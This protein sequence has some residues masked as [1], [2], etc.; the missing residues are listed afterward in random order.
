M[1]NFQNMDLYLIPDWYS[2]SMKHMLKQFL[3]LTPE[4]H[5]TCKVHVMAVR[6]SHTVVVDDTI[7]KY[8]Q[9]SE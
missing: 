4:D 7:K 1:N 5:E 8:Y 2:N 6:G 3:T 9:V